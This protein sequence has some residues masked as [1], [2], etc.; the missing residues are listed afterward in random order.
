MK[1]KLLSLLVAYG[2]LGGLWASDPAL[3]QKSRYPH[4]FRYVSDH[5]GVNQ[6]VGLQNN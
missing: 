4:D 1:A 6:R 2:A 3:A 5:L